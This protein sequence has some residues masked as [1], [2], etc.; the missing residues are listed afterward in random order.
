MFTGLTSM[1]VRI[2]GMMPSTTPISL[3]LAAQGTRNAAI[4]PTSLSLRSLSL[5]QE[6][7]LKK[8][9]TVIEL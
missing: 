9:A 7:G 5:L 6:P 4:F 2:P 8:Y 1:L 3:H